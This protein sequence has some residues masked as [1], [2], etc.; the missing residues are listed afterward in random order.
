MYNKVFIFLLRVKQALWALLKIDANELVQTLDRPVE[1]LGDDSEIIEETMEEKELKL[2]RIILLRSWLLHFISNIH[3]Y[4]MTRVVQSTQ[5]DL[6]LSLME[7]NDL[8]SILNVHN[9]Y[10]S[11]IYDRCF[12]HSSASVL[13][14]AVFK[15]LKSAMVLYKYCTKHVADP[16]K[17]FILETN[18]LKSMEENYAK[19]H[20]FL[21]KTLKAMT[22]KH[23]VPHLDG[24]VAAL[25]HSCPTVVF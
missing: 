4:F 21:A 19:R 3:D 24:L 1:G 11:K 13:K 10:I 25:L 20:Q 15:I 9:R 16:E 2:H 23:N 7:C 5:I 17:I 14:D 18:V 8:D 22:E 12:L 6:D